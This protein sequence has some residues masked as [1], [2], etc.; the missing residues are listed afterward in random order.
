M[1]GGRP[2]SICVSCGLCCDG[3]IF[4][5]LELT[6]GDDCQTLEAV[7]VVLTR[8]DDRFVALQR[9][10][11]LDDTKCRVYA[12]RPQICRDFQCLL[13]QEHEAGEVDTAE[14][15][16]LID[17]TIQ[18]RDRVRAG[19]DSYLGPSAVPSGGPISLDQRMRDVIAKIAA[20]PDPEAAES[21]QTATLMLMVSLRGRL[22]RSFARD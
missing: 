20:Q 2:E 19:V 1:S 5:N 22:R 3:T 8:K 16:A 17:K 7:G 12:G 10:A 6:D 11:A 14:A 21:A 18:L 13:L 4:R 9:C 15:L